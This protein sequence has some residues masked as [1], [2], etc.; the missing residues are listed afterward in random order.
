MVKPIEEMGITYCG[1]MPID[2]IGVNE[3]VTVARPMWH[4]HY[5]QLQKVLTGITEIFRHAQFEQII[6]IAPIPPSLEIIKIKL[7]KSQH[8]PKN[9]MGLKADLIPELCRKLWERRDKNSLGILVISLTLMRTG[10]FRY[11]EW[12]EI[13]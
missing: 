2:Q 3:I 7:G 12:S 4:K 10:S 8:Q 1:D 6:D 11:M 5:P 13:D 9:Y